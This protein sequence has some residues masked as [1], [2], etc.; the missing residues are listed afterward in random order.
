MRP[1]SG[2]ISSSPSS[3]P[4]H[5]LFPIHR[6][7]SGE[8]V[9]EVPYTYYYMRNCPDN[10]FNFRGRVLCYVMRP[11][12]WI[13]SWNGCLLLLSIIGRSEKCCSIIGRTIKSMDEQTLERRELVETMRRYYA[14]TRERLVC[15]IRLGFT[16]WVRGGSVFTLRCLLAVAHFS[17]VS[18]HMNQNS[19]CN[20]Q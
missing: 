8:C 18:N 1:Y 7:D 2:L 12:V 6:Q 14:L 9:Y 17:L 16:N 20:Q 5:H 19:C 4:L 13:M 10:T 11:Q 3:L 15:K